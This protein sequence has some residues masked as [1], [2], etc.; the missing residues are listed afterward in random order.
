M[1]KTLMSNKPSGG[2]KRKT[3]L[4]YIAKD[5]YPRTE[6]NSD[7]TPKKG[8]PGQKFAE[9]AKL[10]AP[11]SQ[12]LMEIEKDQDI[13]WPKP[14]KADPAKLDKSKYCRFY[15]DVGHDTDECRQLKDEIGFLIRKGRLNKYI[16][17]GRGRNNNGRK[18]FEDRRRDQD[19]QGRN[20]Q[21]R[22]PVI[23]AIFGG[24]RP[25][26]PVINIIFGGPTA[27]GLSKNSRKAYTREVMHIVGEAPKRARTGVTMAFDDSDLEGVKFPHDDP[28][29][30]TPIIGNSPVKRV[31]VDNGASVDILLHDTFLRMGY[32][33]SQL[34]P[35]DMPIYGFVGVECPV[36]GII[37]LPTTIGHEPRQAT[38]MLDF[39]VVKASSTYNAIMGRTGIHAFN[40]VPSSYHSFM[41]ADEVGGQVL[42]IKDLDIREN[43]EK[44]TPEN[45]EKVTFV[46]ATL[47][48]PLR[49][50]LVKFL[51]E[52]SDVFTWSVADMPGI[53]PELITH[54]LNVDLS[55]KTVKQKKRS[56]AP[57]RQETIKQEVEKLLEAGFIKE[58]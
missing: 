49:G 47:E 25:R 11:R 24:P 55:Q 35:T 19:N 21:P 8:G 31:L 1:R 48:E 29:V 13:H 18:N 41:K 23:N 6:Q 28:L 3:D 39:V 52:N 15:K 33:D 54:K 40:S 34:T 10:N 56:F 5:K 32:N 46:G 45:P 26:G 16:G 22:G 20:P 12:I 36:K 57:E 43:D 17:E 9:Y 53:D 44:T 4:E 37:K 30:I 42:P 51:Q 50:K 14:L 2:K 27:A 7:S 58:I 38:Q